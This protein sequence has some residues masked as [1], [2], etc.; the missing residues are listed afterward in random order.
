M[1]ALNKYLQ[2]VQLHTQKVLYNIKFVH[3]YVHLSPDRDSENKFSGL[4][5]S[6]VPTC[7]SADI[8]VHF[9]SIND[10]QA[11]KRKQ[12]GYSW[13][14]LVAMQKPHLERDRECKVASRPLAATAW[15]SG[16]GSTV[17]GGGKNLGGGGV[18][19][20]PNSAEAQKT[21]PRASHCSYFFTGK[22]CNKIY[23]Q[24]VL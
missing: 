11:T 22:P 15:G 16:G 3:N 1:L 9:Q 8:V 2:Y 4:L 19:Q 12:G 24:D 6:L 5:P 18:T 17:G 14:Q 10:F 7:V 21:P 20:T 13:P 23:F